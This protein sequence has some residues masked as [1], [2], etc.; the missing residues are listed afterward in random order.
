MRLKY[1]A[2]NSYT[3]EKA[4]FGEPFLCK[5][6]LISLSLPTDPESVGASNALQRTQG[7]G[8]S[9]STTQQIISSEL[10][11]YAPEHLDRYQLST[12][13]LGTRCGVRKSC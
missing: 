1:L 2:K 12:D 4:P 10:N 11:T 6:Q 9:Y 13:L 3:I 8:L 7:V 5:K